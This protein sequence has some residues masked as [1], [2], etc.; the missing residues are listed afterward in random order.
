MNWKEKTEAELYV[1]D[2]DL[3]QPFIPQIVEEDSS[4]LNPNSLPYF[5]VSSLEEGAWDKFAA[6]ISSEI[7]QVVSQPLPERFEK[8]YLAA[9]NLSFNQPY[10][11]MNEV[12]IRVADDL[13]YFGG[14]GTREG[15]IIPKDLELTAS[16]QYGDCK[17]YSAVTTAILRKLGY[18]ARVAFIYS[19][20]SP[21]IRGFNFPISQFNHAIVYAKTQWT[22]L[23]A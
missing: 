16:L 15:Q 17:D 9:K 14:W 12:L 6:T 11:Q 21:V 8:I 5:E 20:Y 19:S 13:N 3:K 1:L 4:I 2:V 18:D 22:R 23:L 7:E 10:E